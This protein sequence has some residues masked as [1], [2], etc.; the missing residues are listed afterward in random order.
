[1]TKFRFLRLRKNRGQMGGISLGN[2]REAKKIEP[3]KQQVRGHLCQTVHNASS[4]AK[5]KRENSRETCSN[6]SSRRYVIYNLLTV[7][8][9]RIAG[10]VIHKV[11][12]AGR[13]TGL[14]AGN[15]TG[16]SRVIV[17]QRRIH[18]TCTRVCQIS[19]S[20]VL[21]DPGESPSDRRE[22]EL[23]IVHAINVHGRTE[24]VGDRN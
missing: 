11:L 2:F 3:Q 7:S 22:K 18:Q 10:I 9:Y 12:I 16:E 17:R 23:F 15:K 13:T 24:P 21:N 8:I 6:Y 19:P 4:T 5:K 20:R 14:P 1:M